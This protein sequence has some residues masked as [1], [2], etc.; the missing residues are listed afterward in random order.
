[1]YLFYIDESGTSSIP[2]N[3]SHFILSGLSIPIWNWKDC[4]KNINAIKARYKLENTE[5]HTGWLI[6]NYTEQNKISNFSRLSSTQR[7]YEIE[8]YRK[9]ELFKLQKS[10]NKGLYRQTKK[11]YKQT[12]PYIHLTLEERKDFVN[13]IA[14][15]IG[16]WG[17]ARLFAECIDKV[18]FDPKRAPKSID[19]QAFEQLVS[20]F[21]QYLRIL[22]SCDGIKNKNNKN[23]GLIIHDNNETIAKRHTELMKLF[24]KQGTF[25]TKISNIIETPLFVNSELTSMIQIA[26]VCAYSLRRYLENNETDL[27]DEIF[28]RAD[29]KDKIVVGVRHFTDDTCA[30]KICLNHKTKNPTLF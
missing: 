28:K 13:E 11:N 30:C 1:M 22:D 24:H 15:T 20:R 9:S 3:T 27:F 26:D 12:Q 29:R 2:G 7:R 6:R 21:E 5:I 14:K 4:E 23:Y 10:S 18:Y 19:E 17:F 16:N 25:W 8:K